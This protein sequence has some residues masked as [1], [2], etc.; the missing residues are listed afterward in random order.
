MLNR[1]FNI[2]L[3][4]YGPGPNL[5]IW[6]FDRLLHTIDSVVNA[7]HYLVERLIEVDGTV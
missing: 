3:R 6:L 2:C 4:S 1:A 5:S 7:G